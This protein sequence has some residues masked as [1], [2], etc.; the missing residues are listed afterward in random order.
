[1][2]EVFREYAQTDIIIRNNCRNIRLD[3]QRDIVSI[4]AAIAI[5]TL[6][7]MLVFH[8]YNGTLITLNKQRELRLL[9]NNI[10][11]WLMSDFLMPRNLLW[12]AKKVLES[13][14]VE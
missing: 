12:S 4:R 9:A 13:M 7:A 5:E 8:L 11:I 1:M 2:E 14:I 6:R 3:G 10:C